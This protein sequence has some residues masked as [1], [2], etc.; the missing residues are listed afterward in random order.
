MKSAESKTLERVLGWDMLRGLCAL[1]V[2]TYHLLVWQNVAEIHVFG[3]YGV[4]LFFVL[5]GASLAYNYA[6]RLTTGQFS[7]RQFLWTRYLRIAPLYVSLMVIVLPW[8]LAKTGPTADLA[9]GYFTNAALLFGFYKPATNAALVGGWSL[10]IEVVFYLIF[11]ALM[12]SFRSRYWPWV[13]FSICSLIQLMWIFG[14]LGQSG[15]FP[16]NF[17]AYHHAPAFV[18][19][20][21]GGC[22]LGYWRLKTASPIGISGGV[23][24]T[25][26]TAGFL[27]MLLLNPSAQGEEI[28]GWRGIVLFAFCFALVYLAGQLRLTRH[29]ARVAKL[30]G[31]GTYG[32]YLLHPVLFFGFVYVLVPLFSLAPPVEWDLSNRLALLVMVL[33]LASMLALLSEE[34]VERPLRKRWK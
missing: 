34:Y 6:D 31:D 11:P 19:Y 27:V 15:A 12:L 28:T 17:E 4:Y 26:F 29:M 24:M 9:F 18:A 23:G 5:S 20:F 2:G 10:G 30:A 16:S 33:T 13:L 32:I 22:L 21:F 14:T 7:L 8:K 3:S 25:A 1:A